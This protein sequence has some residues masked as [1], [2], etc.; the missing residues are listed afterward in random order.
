[1]KRKDDQSPIRNHQSAMIVGL[2]IFL[3]ACS[4]SDGASPTHS[5]T[6]LPHVLYVTQSAGFKHDVLPLSVQ[7]LQALGRQS[8]AFDVTATD[9][10]S[11]VARDTLAR[12]DAVAFFT[13]GELP[14]SA[15]QK[16]ALLDF[17]RSGKGFIGIHSATDTFH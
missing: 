14:M 15:D 5:V 16:A 17:V 7:V 12:F 4:R 9:E 6:A 10:S 2:L 8:G 3:S 1:M 11:L 13:S